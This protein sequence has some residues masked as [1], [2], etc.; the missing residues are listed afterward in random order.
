[1]D[2]LK[3]MTKARVKIAS[4]IFMRLVYPGFKLYVKPLFVSLGLY[5]VVALI[6]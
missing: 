2:K 3:P 1:M 5:H 6:L 4:H